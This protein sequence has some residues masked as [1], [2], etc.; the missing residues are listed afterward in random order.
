MGPRVNP[1][2]WKTTEGA[3][4][5]RKDICL[6]LG[7]TD[8]SI[9]PQGTTTLTLCKPMYSC[10]KEVRM[11]FLLAIRTNVLSDIVQ[12]STLNVGIK[13]IL[14]IVVNFV[15][16]PVY[17]INVMVINSSSR[18]AI[19]GIEL[20]RQ[21]SA[22]TQWTSNQKKI[23]VLGPSIHLNFRCSVISSL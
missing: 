23:W 1:E 4:G 16:K 21:Q 22:W 20:P 17:R 18:A 6:I 8:L 13:L 7:K 9:Q 2:E 10:L 12:W 14:S 15:W 19:V 5:G 11:S 3:G